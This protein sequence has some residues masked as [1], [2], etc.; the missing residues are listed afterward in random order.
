MNRL[1]NQTALITGGGSGIGLA[2]ARAFLDEG[3]RVAIIGRD[4]AKLRQAAAALDGGDRL[5]CFAADV[6][7]ESQVD[8]A[9]RLT[10][11]RFG[12]IHILVNNAGV[13]VKNR[14]F[15]LLSA[16]DW[17][18]MQRTNLDG[19]FYMTRAVFPQM[20]ERR[21]GVIVFVSSV[22]GKSVFSLSGAGYSASKFGMSSLGLSLAAEEKESGVRF[23]VVYPGEVDTPILDYRPEPLTPEQRRSVLKAEDVA[24]AVL[25]IV[26]LPARVCVP[27]LV[28]KPTG[29]RYF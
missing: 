26:T 24:N 13:N 21:D 12:A 11:E 29:Q 9:V 14:S 22:A 15:R 17:R 6:A 27:E 3:A 19:A 4:D 25:F 2:V 5:A 28:I 23:S 18:L 16:D 20:L 7:D 1:Q 8:G 10:T